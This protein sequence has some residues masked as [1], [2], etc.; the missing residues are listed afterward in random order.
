MTTNDQNPT[1]GIGDPYWY[2]WTIGQ[3]YVVDMLNPDCGI[4]SVTLQATEA[5]GLDDVVVVYTDGSSKY[6]QV[7]HTRKESTLTFSII[8]PLLRSMSKAWSAQ[9]GKW[10]KCTPVLYS[11][12]KIG[13]SSFT[14]KKENENEYERPALKEFLEYLHSKVSVANKLDDIK[15]CKDWLDAWEE[16]CNQLNELSSDE[17]KLEFLKLLVIKGDQPGLE[18]LKRN[19]TQKISVT[20]GISTEKAVSVFGQLDHALRKWGTTLRGTREY[21]NSEDV[22]EVLSLTAQ[23]LVGDHMLTPPE[24]FFPSRQQFLDDLATELL[25]GANPIMFLTGEPGQGKTSVVSALANRR[26]PVIDLRYHAF[27]PITPQTEILPADAGVTTKAEVLWGD[28]LTELRSFFFKGRLSQF[29]VP[30]RNDFLT[31]DQLREEVLRLA[32][33]LGKERGRPTVIAIDGIDH[34]ARAGV[35][36]YSFL[37][38]LVPPNAVPEHVRFLIVGQSAASYDRYPFWLKES[39]SGVSN[40]VVDGIQ[41]EDIYKLLA[42]EEI[43]LPDDQLD[44]TVR[45]INEVA[46]GNTLTAIFAVK[47]AKE[48][49]NVQ[50]LQ[51]KLENRRLTNGLS[52]YYDNIWSVAVALLQERYPF[53]GHR[54]AGIFSL[55]NERVTGQDLYKIF[56]G[57]LGISPV[58]WT[59]VLRALSPLVMEETNGFRLIHNDVRVQLTKQVHGRPE[60]LREVASLIAD[61]YWK[62]PDKQEAKHANLFEMLRK[63]NRHMDQARVF[64]PEYVM[65]GFALGRPIS[66][67]HEQCKQ[68]MLSVVETGDWDCIHTLSCAAA[69][70]VQLHKSVSWMDSR[71]EY[72]PDIPPIL[73]S[74][75]RVPNKESW[76]LDLVYDT[77]VD[78]FRLIQAEERNRAY[79]LIRRW[80]NDISPID[81][82]T[83]LKNDVFEQRNDNSDLNRKFKQILHLWG[84]ITFHIGFLWNFEKEDYQKIDKTKHKIWAHFSNGLMEEAIEMGEVR[85]WIWS[86]RTSLFPFISDIEENLLKLAFKRRWMEVGFTLKG[87]S[88]QRER[89]PVTFKIKAAALSLFTGRKDLYEIWVKPIVEEGFKNLE[90]IDSGSHLEEHTLLYCMVGFLLGWTQPYR[91]NSSIGAEGVKSYLKQSRDNNKRGH[92]SVLISGSALAGKWLGTYKRRGAETAGQIITPNEV[93][94]VLEAL[95]I[96]TRNFNETVNYYETPTKLI[97]EILIECSIFIGRTADG[98]VYEFVK[99]F[100]KSYPVNYMMEICW[101]YLWNRGDDQFLGEWFHHWCGPEGKVWHED[102]TSRVDIVNRLSM[103]ADEIGLQQEAGMARNLL[104]WGMISYTGHKEDVLDNPKEWYRE[105]SN[106]NPSIWENEGKLLLEISQEAT[107]LG[108]NRIAV[109]VESVVASTVARKGTAD[110]WRLMNA[111]NMREPLIDNV[112]MLFDGLISSLQYAVVSERDLLSIWSFGI[113]TL[114]WQAGYDRCYLEDLKLTLLLVAEQNGITSLE[115]KLK[116][117]GPA[118]YNARGDRSC[119]SSIPGRWYKD[120]ET[121]WIRNRPQNT[122]FF[123]SLIELPIKSAIDH[124]VESNEA[125]NMENLW[126]G[127]YIVGN[128]LKEEKP[129]GYP[130]YLQR[131]VQLILTRN[132]LPYPWVG[133]NVSLA[134]QTLIPLLRDNVRFNLLEKA[135]DNLDFNSEPRIWLE[136]AAENLDQFCRFRA[137]AMGIKDLTAGLKRHLELHGLWIRG[138]G[139]LPDMKRIEIPDLQQIKSVPETWSEFAIQYFFRILQSNNLT[140]IELALRGLWGLAQVS[141]GDISYFAEHWDEL[142]NRSK[143]RVLLF[144]ERAAACAPNT[145]EPFSEIVQK[146]YEGSDLS[147]KLQSRLILKVIERRTGEKCP[148]WQIQMYPE[149]EKFMAISPANRG[150]FDVPSIQ[151]GLIYEI[152]GSDVVQNLLNKLEVVTSDNLE[153]VERKFVSYSNTRSTKVD[154]IE[155]ISIIPGQI[156]VRNLPHRDQLMKVLYSELSTGR[157]K[158]VPVVALAQ[159]LLKT[160]EPFVLLQSPTPALDADEW[161]IDY[162]IEKLGGNK[163]MLLER[164]FPHIQAGLSDDEVVIGSVLRTFSRTMDVEVVFNT[165]IQ[166]RGFELSKIYEKTTMS[167][168]S[169]ALYDS[170]RFDPQDLRSPILG[171]TYKSGGISEFSNQSMLCYPSLI[172]NDVFNWEPTAD[173]PLIW[174]EDGIPAIRFEH[175]HGRI[176]DIAQ[177]FFFRQPFLQRWVCSKKALEKL[178]NELEV[179]ISH[180][181]FVNV[182][183]VRS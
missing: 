33:I 117:L 96:R 173:N 47:E 82:I 35:D 174:C 85:E 50:D 107:K 80:F 155:S 55:T 151:R 181:S 113:G 152:H 106:E 52:S 53:V 119:Y 137:V 13:T 128:R 34:A 69:C 98:T 62:D 114:N 87:I 21:I 48:I 177:D 32:D 153:D 176:R 131:L 43:T 42:E 54:L 162:E 78:A 126:L 165:V 161:A 3:D 7:K 102:V 95:V 60:R 156:K 134:Y 30:I 140:R 84:K 64:T 146:C 147:L 132:H 100:C 25:T 8:L 31:V 169:F 37:D 41:E 63:S 178:E 23:E 92:I 127:I 183:R 149:H 89:L 129:V 61:Y 75:G 70:L 160:D 109:Y 163:K 124:L 118:E 66:E 130:M 150:V 93:G 28:L 58:D 81:F 108:D 111:R 68:A 20:F 179:T 171:T 168:R 105:L 166:G 14:V 172:W 86:L 40:W 157:W 19:V 115:E 65:E 141:P 4:E 180:E 94:Q 110:M 142:N 99:E 36:Q 11:N 57:V 158:D 104:R 76:T 6:V 10:T 135:I 46:Q 167:G 26:E 49:S 12:R 125:E 122:E 22:Y 24:P 175:L 170:A 145:Y 136:S 79:G 159:A 139:F 148:E 144:L 154:S 72:A 27:K 112:N 103:L 123:Q 39:S 44:V 5:Q 90:T 1:A 133:S 83:I 51:L 17:E 97:V 116:V 182:K 138:N 56:S 38:T 59:E 164:I 67:I 91:E 9:K 77:M 74:E 121:E 45:L 88:K 73:F 2:E 18:D 15:M 16:W 101:R 29:K 143:E 120:A 71:F